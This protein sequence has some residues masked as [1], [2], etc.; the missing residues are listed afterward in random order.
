MVK[1]GS[2]GLDIQQRHVSSAKNADCGTF[3]Y[4]APEMYEGAAV[5]KSDVWSL[6]VSIIE[7]AEGKNPYASCAVKEAVCNGAV[8]SLSSGSS[9]LVDFVSKCLVKDVHDRCSV[10]ELMEVSI[11]FCEMI[12]STHS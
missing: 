3:L 4:M 10:E 1:L 2:F 12:V 7:M 8:P 5:L 9:D 11:R 6:G